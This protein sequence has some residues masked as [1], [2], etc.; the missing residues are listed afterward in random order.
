MDGPAD[1]DE[2]GDGFSAEIDF[3]DPGALKAG[4]AAGRASTRDTLDAARAAM[5]GADEALARGSA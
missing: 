1:D 4:A 3:I 2:A 5:S